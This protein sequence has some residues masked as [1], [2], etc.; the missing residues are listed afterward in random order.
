MTVEHKSPSEYFEEPCYTVYRCIAWEGVA[1]GVCISS[2]E[3]TVN[4]AMYSTM[5]I[6]GVCCMVI[7]QASIS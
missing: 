7:N 5:P 3:E 4:M 1:C 2:E 6:D